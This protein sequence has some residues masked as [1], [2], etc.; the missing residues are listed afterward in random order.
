MTSTDV[1]TVIDK[2]RK[3]ETEAAE[4]QRLQTLRKQAP[5]VRY[6]DTAMHWS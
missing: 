2:I 4:A 5:P 3:D 6:S 1:R